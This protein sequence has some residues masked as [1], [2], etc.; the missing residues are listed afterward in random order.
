M[1]V[2]DPNTTII[3]VLNGM[4]YAFALFLISIGLNIL[5][6]LMRIL[7]IAHGGFYALGAFLTWAL[8]SAAAK[9]GYP[10]YV[11]WLC[12]PA[13]AFL[14]GLVGLVIEPLLFKRLYRLRE[15]YSLLATFGLMLVF[16]DSLRMLFGGSPL[17]ANELFNYVGI[18]TIVG[19]PYPAYNFVIYILAISVAIGLW[20]LFFKTKLGRVIRGTAQDTDMARSLGVN[21][22]LLSTQTFFIAIFVVGLG[23]A[24][25]LPATSAYSGMGFEPIV[26][27]FAV[28][29]IGGLGS[30]K[31]ALVAS[32][33]IGLVRAFGIA[34]IPELELAF[35]FMILVV[36]LVFRPRGLFGKKFTREEK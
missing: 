32:T 28:M 36:T 24:I 31:G 22:S 18:M 5:Y 17:S 1:P 9:L 29:I 4:Y 2:V 23:G 30:L 35:V 26:L 27:S 21:A 19:R 12:I 13:A 25:Y 10:I 3:I 20:T 7:N 15:E 8:M 11:V 33:I 6:G 16:D 34:I 14:V